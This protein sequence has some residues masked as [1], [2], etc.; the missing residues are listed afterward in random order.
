[1]DDQK[2][3]QALD[4]YPLIPP[5]ND[6]GATTYGQVSDDAYHQSDAATFHPYQEEREPGFPEE[7]Q[8]PTDTDKQHDNALSNEQLVESKHRQHG[9]RAWLKPEWR[10]P[11]R[12]LP[13]RTLATWSIIATLVIL[14][15]LTFTVAYRYNAIQV[16]VTAFKIGQQQSITQYI[17]GG[18]VTY[19]YQELNVSYPIAERAINILV[20]AGDSVKPGQ[21][22]IKL[23]T[24]Q[25]SA[26]IAQASNNVAA[27]QAYLNSVSNAFPY[28]PF[29]VAAAQQGLQ[30]AQNKYNA[31]IAQ[32]SSGL[33]RNGNLISPMQ[34]IVTTININP[35]Q[36]F[37]A[38]TI[39]LT[40]M[41]QS[42][43]IVRAK[44]PLESLGQVRPGMPVQVMP[45]ALP[46]TTMQGTVSSIIPQADP[47]TD[48]FA[49]WVTVPNPQN[50]LLAG[51]SA[52][53]RIQGQL[54][55]FVV[56]R[57]AVLNPDHESTVFM[58]RAGHAYITQVHIV[59]R[60]ETSVF[61]DAGLTRGDLILLLPADKVLSNGQAVLVTETKS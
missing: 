57:L 54:N 13:K 6:A 52:F 37:A 59:G 35:G 27:A 42:S 24:T 56:P 17:G 49:V 51:M 29:T 46:N 3:S 19:P 26:Q 16:D 61:V 43:I 39:L 58:I 25:L 21:P 32:S 34:G 7:L 9:K 60:S 40:V 10:I 41:D 55:A 8:V 31:L 28:N 14:G 48:T 1:M 47:Q 20:K 38:N 33:L 30:V 5:A 50:M 23:D 12:H 36:V 53:V 11:A 45:S 22:L 4:D 44:I 18:G 15:V 2:W